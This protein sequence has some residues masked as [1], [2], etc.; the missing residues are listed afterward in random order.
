MMQSQ[1]I[2]VVE[3]EIIEIVVIRRQLQR[4]ANRAD[5]QR[6]TDGMSEESYDQRER[7]TSVVPVTFSFP[8]LGCILCIPTLNFYGNESE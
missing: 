4:D 6:N 1:D 5:A 2:G 8:T 3:A 7:E